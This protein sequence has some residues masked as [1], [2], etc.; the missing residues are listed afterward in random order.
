MGSLTCG[1]LEGEVKSGLRK[2]VQTYQ[3]EVRLTANQDLL[4][5]NIGAQKPAIKAALATLGFELP[6]EPAPCAACDCMPALPT[7]GLA[8]TEAERA[9]PSVL[10]RLDALLQRL[11]IDQS[12][13]VRMTGCPNGCA[14]PTWPNSAWWEVAS[15]NTSCAWRHTEP[16]DTGASF[17][18]ENAP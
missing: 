11:D 6:G 4:L 16:P 14:R 10:D 12:L 1:R 3:L 13:L 2:L 18:A 17:P 9:L 5:C 8:I 7:C 15:I